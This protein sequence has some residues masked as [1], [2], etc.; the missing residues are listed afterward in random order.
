MNKSWLWSYHVH[1]LFPTFLFCKNIFGI[2]C[3]LCDYFCY[4]ASARPCSWKSNI[5]VHIF[6]F[7]KIGEKFYFKIYKRK[8]LIGC[9]MTFSV[10]SHAVPG[11]KIEVL[12]CWFRDLWF[13]R[14][15][16]L[17]KKNIKPQNPQ[18]HYLAVFPQMSH[19]WETPAICL[20]SM[21]GATWALA[22]SFPHTLQVRFSI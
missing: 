4:A 14:P 3:C 13:L 9:R 20:D 11:P 5:L 12:H 1:Y 15:S 17:L 16:L 19:A 8:I 2:I 10:M 22:P 21:W 18:R 6:R 7:R